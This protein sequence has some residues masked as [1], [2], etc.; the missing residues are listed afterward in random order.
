MNTAVK[1]GDRIRIIWM[2]D[3]NGKDWQVTQMIG[4]TYTVDFIDD[5]GQIHL[6]GKGIAVIPEL[7]R[8]ELL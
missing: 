2:D 1:K 7:D 5:A 4:N 8:F 6:E 3:C